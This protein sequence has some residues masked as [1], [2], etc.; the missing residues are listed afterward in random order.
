MAEVN[1]YFLS[2]ELA[3]ESNK[4]KEWKGTSCIIDMLFR[5]Y[6]QTASVQSI[7]VIISFSFVA[8]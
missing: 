2:T 1:M 7:F 6:F 3:T 8:V 4:N 5:M